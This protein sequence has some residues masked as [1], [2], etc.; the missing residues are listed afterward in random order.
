[1]TKWAIRTE[2]ISGV[3]E[4]PDNAVVLSYED[5]EDNGEILTYMVPFT[6]AEIEARLSESE[7]AFR[8]ECVSVIEGVRESDS[9]HPGT[10][11][12][13][14]LLM[15]H[16]ASGNG[17]KVGYE[18]LLGMLKHICEFDPTEVKV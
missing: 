4:L 3:V 1:M 2:I 6:D 15:S 17:E 10:R 9:S 12:M 18:P 7:I 11:I 13:S 16:D 8:R 14:D 5:D